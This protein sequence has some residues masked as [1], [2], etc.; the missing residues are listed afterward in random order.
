M[1][2][3]TMMPGS[4]DEER[5]ALEDADWFFDEEVGAWSHF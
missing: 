3:A 1:N 2:P 4:I 5:Q